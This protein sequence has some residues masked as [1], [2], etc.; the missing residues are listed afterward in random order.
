MRTIRLLVTVFVVAVLLLTDVQSVY[1]ANDD[2]PKN[3]L[4]E[5]VKGFFGSIK[6]KLAGNGGNGKAEV[7]TEPP[8][9][10]EEPVTAESEQE[11]AETEESQATGE[12]SADAEGSDEDGE[13]MEL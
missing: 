11:E 6:K 10:V 3:E 13:T 1:G 7:K 5:K 8:V 12:V 9:A 4:L 2:K